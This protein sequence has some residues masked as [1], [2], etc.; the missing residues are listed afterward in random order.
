MTEI[1]LYGHADSGHSHKVALALAIS[2]LPHRLETIDIWA[3]AATRPAAFLAANPMAEVPTLLIDD[4]PL[5]QSAS[6]LIELAQRFQILGG[7][8]PDELRRAREVMFWEANRIGMCLPQLIW[9]KSNPE[10]V[11]SGAVQ[12]LEQRYAVDSDRFDKLLGDKD[13]FHGTAPGIADCCVYGYAQWHYKAGVPAS[14]AMAEWLH[15][16]RKLPGY[17]SAVQCFPG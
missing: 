9:A 1:L 15:R 14:P 5:T 13:Y 16:M 11:P 4:L 2:G 8:N 3:P 6:I 17:R 7:E 12:W 10:D